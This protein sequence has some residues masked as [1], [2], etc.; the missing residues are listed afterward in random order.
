MS[1]IRGP[2]VDKFFYVLDKKI[3][4]DKRLSWQ[5]RGLLVYLLGKPNHWK[6]SVE[7]LKAET[8]A[9]CKPTSRDGIYS[10]MEELTS[11]GYVIR[12]PARD[13]FGRMAGFDYLVNDTPLPDLP[14]TAEPLTANTTLVST[15]SK[16][17]LK[18]VKKHLCDEAFEAAWKA[19]P[20]RDGSNPKASALKAW[21]AR[22]KEG[23]TDQAMIEGVARYASYCRQ[24]ETAGTGFVMQTVRFFGT[25]KEFENAWGMPTAIGGVQRNEWEIPTRAEV[26]AKGPRS[27]GKIPH[28]KWDSGIHQFVFPLSDDIDPR[29]VNQQ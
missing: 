20:K 7:A 25:N 9:T 19:Y 3:S 16:Q 18:E 4:E 12:K 5:A 6:V 11:T 15:D 23:I 29:M 13:E 22:I 17:G 8:S 10:I 28:D 26:M 14:L 21:K 24:K 2:K 1:I 27:D